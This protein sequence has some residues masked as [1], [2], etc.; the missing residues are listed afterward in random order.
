MNTR[1]LSGLRGESVKGFA[2]ANWHYAYLSTHLSTLVL[3]GPFRRRVERPK[4]PLIRDPLKGPRKG[5]CLFFIGKPQKDSPRPPQ[6]SVDLRGPR[7]W[8]CR[9]WRPRRRSGPRPLR[10]RRLQG[11]LPPKNPPYRWYGS[12]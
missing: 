10:P 9:P 6:S 5:L 3:F 4:L 7:Q 2:Q 1:Y 12:I 8:P 11:Q